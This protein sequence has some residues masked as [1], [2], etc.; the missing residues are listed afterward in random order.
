MIPD[1][2]TKLL[3]GDFL[4]FLTESRHTEEIHHLCEAQIP[5]DHIR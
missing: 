1:P 3:S 4:Y 5:K 2:D